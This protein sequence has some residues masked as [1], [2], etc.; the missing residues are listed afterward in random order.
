VNA[1]PENSF[2]LDKKLPTSAAPVNTDANANEPLVNAV[3][4][5]IDNTPRVNIEPLNDN[6]IFFC[7]VLV[8]KL[9]SIFASDCQRADQFE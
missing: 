7:L 4:K 6:F 5:I 8:N 1:N 2:V 9:I 3:K